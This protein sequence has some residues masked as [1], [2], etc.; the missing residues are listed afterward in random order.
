MGAIPLLPLI[1]YCLWSYKYSTQ[2]N[3]RY[4]IQ[5]SS[6]KSLHVRVDERLLIIPCLM[7][8]SHIPRMTNISQQIQIHSS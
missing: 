7:R 6:C 1:L 3:A 4:Q 8:D 2:P 5:F